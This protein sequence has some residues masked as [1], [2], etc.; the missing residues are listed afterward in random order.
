[1]EFLLKARSCLRFN[2]LLC[3]RLGIR[4]K[5]LHMKRFQSWFTRYWANTKFRG[6]VG[7]LIKLLQ[8]WVISTCFPLCNALLKLAQPSHS[9]LCSPLL[10]FP[11]AARLHYLLWEL[12]PPS[13][14]ELPTHPLFSSM[15]LWIQMPHPNHLS[16]PINQLVLA[17]LILR[18]IWLETWSLSS[19]PQFISVYC[20]WLC[21][22]SP[23]LP[24]LEKTT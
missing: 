13:M 14:W 17:T 18:P 2:H 3:L 6:I 5:F 22:F 4:L 19:S 21:S 8:S 11:V 9:G 23:W 15:C 10:N 20:L 1:M 24:L 12:Y 16:I 7:V